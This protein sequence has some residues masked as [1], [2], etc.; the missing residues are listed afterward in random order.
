LI[1]SDKQMGLRAALGGVGIAFSLEEFAQPYID[2]GRLEPLLQAWTGDFPGH[3]LCY[4]RQ[5]EMAPALRAVI[6]SIR[7]QAAERTN[8]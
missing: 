3:H 4:P 7:A 8:R 5:R 2:D 6:D 1:V